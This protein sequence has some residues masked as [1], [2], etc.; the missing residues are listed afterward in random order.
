ML[1][2]SSTSPS[3]RRRQKRDSSNNNSF[4]GNSDDGNDDN[5]EEEIERGTTTTATHNGNDDQEEEEDYEDEEIDIGHEEA[6]GLISDLQ[7]FYT[8]EYYGDN[9]YDDDDYYDDDGRSGNRLMIIV[10]GIVLIIAF[11][12]VIIPETGTLWFLKS[13]ARI[14]VEYTCPTSTTSSIYQSM[15]QNTTKL[16]ETNSTEFLKSYKDTN[17]DLWGVSYDSFKSNMN[18]FVMEF[19]PKY[20]TDGDTIY[21][22]SCGNGLGIIMTLEILSS[23]KSSSKSSSGKTTTTT[24][25]IEN[26]IVYGSDHKQESIAMFNAIMDSTLF[27]TTTT[28]FHAEKGVICYIDDNNNN[29]DNKVLSS[30]SMT[31]NNNNNNENTVDTVVPPSESFDLVYTGHISPLKDPLQFG[32]NL[33]ILAEYY[34]SI[35]KGGEEGGDWRDEKLRQ[36]AQEKQEVW[37]GTKVAELARIAKPGRPVI[38]EQVSEEYCNANFDWG[39]VSK[40]WW[41]KSAKDDTYNWDIDY[42]SIEIRDDSLFKE[43]YHVFMLKNG[44]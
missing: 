29:N 3:S 20:L 2:L 35:C 24:T 37:Y 26:L 22:S 28:T 36:Q 44:S 31:N 19:F 13:P 1:E 41:T 27:Q 23:S 17:Y 14:P 34:T 30:S 10:M 21:A 15:Y 43:R 6:T 33:T 16:I 39:G 38:I 12:A 5:A 7:S 8:D 40:D 32:K 25:I 11:L 42:T 18:D 4:D 9:D